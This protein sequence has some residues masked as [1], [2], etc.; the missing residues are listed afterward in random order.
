M[1]GYM[2]LTRLASV[3]YGPWHLGFSWWVGEIIIWQDILGGGFK[4]VLF[5]P[6]YGKIPILT[7]IFQ[8][9]WNHQL[10]YLGLM[11]DEA[12]K[13]QVLPRPITKCQSGRNFLLLGM[14]R[15]SSWRFQHGKCSTAMN[16]LYGCQLTIFMISS[17]DCSFLNWSDS[18]RQ[19]P[20]NPLLLPHGDKQHTLGRYIGY[21]CN[22][23]HCRTCSPFNRGAIPQSLP[24]YS[25]KRDIW[26]HL[27][28]GRPKKMRAD[29]KVLHV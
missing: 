2:S 23:V 4:H 17:D 21:P 25:A 18:S 15:T 29:K 12:L 6:L 1:C 20:S 26:K 10:G 11:D 28:A 14:C 9:G 7:S 24:R 27:A 13:I 16:L 3:V 19:L 8:R 5:S 22:S